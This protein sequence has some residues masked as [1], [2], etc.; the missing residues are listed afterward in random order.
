MGHVRCE[1][2]HLKLPTSKSLISHYSRYHTKFKLAREI[3]RLSLLNKIPKMFTKKN[4]NKT[5][6]VSEHESKNIKQSQTLFVND[7]VE[8]LY[9][10]NE[11]II[12]DDKSSVDLEFSFNENSSETKENK[13]IPVNEEFTYKPVDKSVG[14]VNN[15]SVSNNKISSNSELRKLLKLKDR[16]AVLK[17]GLSTSSSSA[18][19]EDSLKKFSFRKK[20]RKRKDTREKTRHYK[21]NITQMNNCE[22]LDENTGS[23]YLCHCRNDN[24]ITS[25]D[26]A[27]LKIAS[28]TES[29]SDTG[30]NHNFND[31]KV[32]CSKCG[33]GYR[34]ENLLLDHMKIHETHCRVCNEIFPTE[35]LFKE[36]IQSHIFKV[37]VCHV[38]NY[39]F[40]LRHML[41]KHFECHI[42]D[43][44]LESVIDMEE[45]YKVTPC[46]L[47]NMSYQ[48][49]INSILCYLGEHHDAFYNSNK[50]AKIHCDICFSEINYN[51][52]ESHLQRVHYIY[53]C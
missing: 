53:N 3:L 51:E 2:C 18:S 45:D 48:T 1:I 17:M 47:P 38:C 19:S 35:Q 9:R 14:E 27:D 41:Q 20:I 37:F 15:N 44:I 16:G 34:D 31:L 6:K 23:F 5:E 7:S 36:H 52:Y 24:K 30:K 49:S 42:E 8:I 32:F 28:D 33:N 11:I 46:S 25:D 50:V 21:I 22:S 4:K 39:E 29:A 13:F 12:R 40:P 10:N 26:C 43:S